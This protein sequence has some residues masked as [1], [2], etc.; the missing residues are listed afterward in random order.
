MAGIGSESWLVRVFSGRA[1]ASLVFF[2][3]SLFF[4]MG[5]YGS[6]KAC[7]ALGLALFS[8]FVFVLVCALG[9]GGVFGGAPSR[10]NFAVFF[11][12]KQHVQHFR[13]LSYL[14]L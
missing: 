13:S 6:G 2:C 11:A 3:F 9:A 14:Y 1:C 5:F 4:V 7:L 10:K 8:L 12:I